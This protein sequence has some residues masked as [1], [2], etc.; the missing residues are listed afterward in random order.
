MKTYVCFHIDQYGIKTDYTHIYNFGGVQFP[1]IALYNLYNA[2]TL[3]QQA[4]T[5]NNPG[6]TIL[7]NL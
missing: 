4:G 7:D 6:E 1:S 2:D 5:L 3:G